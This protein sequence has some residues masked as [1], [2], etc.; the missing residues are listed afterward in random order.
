MPMRPSGHIKNMRARLTL[1]LAKYQHSPT[2]NKKTRPLRGLAC[3][4]RA[5]L[6]PACATFF[7]TLVTS[8]CRRASRGKDHSALSN[9]ANGHAVGHL[10]R[11]HGRRGAEAFRSATVGRTQNPHERFAWPMQGTYKPCFRF[12][13]L[14]L[15]AHARV[16]GNK[17]VLS[18][19]VRPLG[20]SEVRPFNR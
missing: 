11:G 18:C 14:G 20:R 4:S 9:S 12:F 8:G 10:T 19:T 15:A 7:H 6:R 1:E 16:S 5:F 13:S 3:I 2:S 17:R